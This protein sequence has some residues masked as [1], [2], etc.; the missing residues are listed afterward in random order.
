M[1]NKQFT[2]LAVPGSLSPQSSNMHILRYIGKTFAGT[3]TN[4]T[5]FE[6]VGNIPHFNPAIDTEPA[7][8]AVETWRQQLAYADAVLICTPE[9]AFGVPG[10]LKNA[11]DWTV[12]SDSFGRKPVGIIT[13][14][15]QGDKAHA[16]LLL[17][18][19]AL[20]AAVVD[21]ATLLISFVRTKVNEKGIVT[22]AATE[23]SLL[24][25][26]S[27]LNRA[28]VNHTTDPIL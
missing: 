4:F 16:S 10:S 17:T 1:K 6:G 8:T 22:D 27:N 24:Q 15:S 26:I 11:L 28:M 25:V 13:A 2:I 5:I 18:C 20:G 19:K 12:S 7:P 23:Q 3:D 21:G 9:Y 14:S